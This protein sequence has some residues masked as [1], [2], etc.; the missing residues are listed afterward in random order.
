MITA[1]ALDNEINSL[2]SI[3]EY[4]NQ[5]DGLFMAD[6]FTDPLKGLEF[7]KKKPAVDLVFIDMNMHKES[8]NGLPIA[9][10]LPPH[11]KLVLTSSCPESATEDYQLDVM[12]YL[13]KPYT[14]KSLEHSLQKF[15][16]HA[17]KS[18]DDE[19]SYS[20]PSPTNYAKEFIFIKT[21]YKVTKI[22]LEELKFIE[23]AGNY[24]ALHTEKSKILTLQNMK[25][26]E[27][28]LYPYKFIR[29][30]K[31]FIV[32]IKYIDAIENNMIYIGDKIIPVGD[33]YRDCLQ[34]FIDR[35][36][37]LF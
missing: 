24:V 1:V 32:S 11:I 25:A 13:V 3:L 7:I 10:Q 21:E 17:N 35:F 20:I 16:V 34:R 9:S 37:K 31:S 4:S 36:A 27:E 26:F 22:K 2:G 28:Y 19:L 8:V 29:V 6:T 30:H 23:G 33:S 5:I 12:D 15:K 18:N 14:V